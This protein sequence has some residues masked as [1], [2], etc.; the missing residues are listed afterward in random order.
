MVVGVAA[1]VG[2]GLV[3]GAAVPL[4]NQWRNDPTNQDWAAFGVP[5][6]D[7]SCDPISEEPAQGNNDH[8]PDGEEISY[9]PAPPAFGPHY[10]VPAGFNRKFYTPDDRPPVE[11][12]VHNL[13]HG[14]TILWYDPSV[15]AEQRDTLRDLA[16][17]V[18]EDEELSEAV[19]GKFVAAP[20]DPDRGDFPEGKE[21]V[22]A[23]WGAEQGYRQECGALSG[24]VVRDFVKAY[25]FSD[26]PE[27]FGA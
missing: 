9:D 18:T 27:P 1:V 14:Y 23:H 17:K 19:N 26:S 12:L 3:A 2:V 6:S 16:T 10:N 22:L 15:P 7:A 24:E 5:A 11:Q 4:I 13:E 20:W 21:Y 8:R 25:P